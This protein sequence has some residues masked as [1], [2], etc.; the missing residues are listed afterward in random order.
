MKKD[1][2][3]GYTGFVGSNLAAKHSFSGNFN[4]KNISDAFGE[5]PNLLVYAGVPAEMYLANQDPEADQQ[6]I[7]SAEKNIQLIAPKQIILIS[8]IAVY[9]DTQ[10]ADED[11]V[12]EVDRL[13]PYG[14]NRHALEV[15]VEEHFENSLIVRLPALYGINLKKNFLYDYIHIIPSVL[16][17][18]KLKELSVQEPALLEY[19]IS[20]GNGF[21]RCKKLDQSEEAALKMYFKALGFSALNFTDSRSKY[22]FYPL[23]RLW[24]HLEAAM[25]QG[26][27]KLNITTA[28]IEIAELYA[29]LDGNSFYNKLNKPLFDYNLRSKYVYLIGGSN[30]YLMKK[31][32]VLADIF[33]YIQREQK[34]LRGEFI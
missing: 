18:A 4:S 7:L 10:G 6:A 34:L 31:D 15:W 23:D 8:T 5:H 30:G 25:Q 13:S 17:E 11:T 33:A 32:E 2:L 3:V 14:T 22:Q 27:H 28:P 1:F 9:P 19:Y 16:T 21:F 12:I 26:L 24:G 29:Y 20:Q